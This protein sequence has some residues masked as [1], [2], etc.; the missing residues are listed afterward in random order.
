VDQARTKGSEHL[1]KVPASR[2]PVEGVL[3]ES[4]PGQSIITLDGRTQGL[5]CLI[6]DPS[7]GEC[8]LGDRATG[9]SFIIGQS[10]GVSLG[11]VGLDFF[12][13][14]PPFQPIVPGGGT[15]AVM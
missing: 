1:T 7:T 8:R 11:A 12:P 2:W 9:G 4:V 13:I 14:L 10:P 6:I 3:V 15:E 5:Q